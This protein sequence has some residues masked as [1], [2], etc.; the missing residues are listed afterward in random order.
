M[1]EG[2]ALSCIFP[3][4]PPDLVNGTINGTLRLTYGLVA[5]SVPGLSDLHLMSQLQLDLVPD[6]NIT[7]FNNISYRAGSNAVIII[8]VSICN[9][10]Y[11]CI[12]LY[13]CLV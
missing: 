6:P 1:S 9:C 13:Q 2:R 4:I 5:A 12:I 8:N 11:S 7:S 10:T 3:A